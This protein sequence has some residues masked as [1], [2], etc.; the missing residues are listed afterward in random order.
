MAGVL[1]PTC[2]SRGYNTSRDSNFRLCPLSIGACCYIQSWHH[3][4]F[5]RR[6]HPRKHSRRPFWKAD[7]MPGHHHVCIGSLTRKYKSIQRGWTLRGENDLCLSPQLYAF[8]ERAT[9][10]EKPCDSISE[11]FCFRDDARHSR[12]TEVQQRKYTCTILVA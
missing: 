5:K 12:N 6:N 4:L 1:R 2:F 8:T 11:H 10:G 3:T 7:R 9:L